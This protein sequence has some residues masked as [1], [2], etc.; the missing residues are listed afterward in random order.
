MSDSLLASLAARWE[1]GDNTPDLCAEIQAAVA[2]RRA[3]PGS[4]GQWA[5][6]C[7]RAGL[8]SLAFSEFQLALRDDPHDAV[9][10]FHLAQHYRERGDTTRALGLLER[11]LADQPPQLP[12]LEA[13]VSILVED[14]A[15]PRAEQAIARAEQHGLPPADAAAGCRRRARRSAAA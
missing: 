11:L 12:W 9:A 3:E 7:E 5:L 10:A 14:G 6:L 4:H 8:V 15:E 1:A 13:Y 2:A